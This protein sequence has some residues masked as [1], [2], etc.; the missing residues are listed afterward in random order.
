MTRQAAGHA[1]FNSSILANR[2]KQ[3]GFARI[4]TYCHEQKEEELF[5]LIYIDQIKL[6]IEQ[7]RL[8]HKALKNHKDTIIK[9]MNSGS[10]FEIKKAL[11]VN[12]KILIEKLRKHINDEDDIFSEN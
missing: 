12:G 7:M 1:L 5:R 10:D 6:P 11:H 2:N 4:C 3:V 8:D 9:A